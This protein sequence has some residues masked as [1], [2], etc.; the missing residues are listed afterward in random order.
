MAVNEA[1]QLL[2]RQMRQTRRSHEKLAL[3]SAVSLLA[4]ALP[5]GGGLAQE[6][7]P[8]DPAAG[9]TIISGSGVYHLPEGVY[10]PPVLRP[11]TQESLPEAPERVT[12]AAPAP[13]PAPTPAPAPAPA[14]ETPP[15]PE[16]A[17]TPE[18]E[19]PAQPAAESQQIDQTP[20]PV[21]PAPAPEPA[22]APAPAPAPEPQAAPAPPPSA[23]TPPAPAPEPAP[24]PE[25]DVAQEQETPAEEAGEAAAPP[26]VPVAPVED[27]TGQP[28]APAEAVEEA[29]PEEEGE[30]IPPELQQPPGDV[31]TL[32]FEPGSSRLPDGAAPTLAEAS[33]RAKLRPGAQIT[34]MAYAAGEEASDQRARRLSLARAL[35]VRG[36]LI[37]QGIVST[38][39]E[40][41]PLGA[42][43]LSGEADRVDIIVQR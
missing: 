37:Q 43:N 42:S 25:S 21:A 1:Q 33:D 9:T 30:Q 22:P 3:L 23:E 5:L 8:E 19:A 2:N 38:R 40:I 18:P 12:D 34:L 26:A 16:V 4:V 27:V 41:R 20:V 36:F 11:Q 28:D 31:F 39:V 29:E 10:V 35:A 7:I 17:A 13:T 14:A 32:A 6:T 24:E 15:E